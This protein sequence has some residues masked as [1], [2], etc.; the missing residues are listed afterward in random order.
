MKINVKVKP[1][2]RLVKIEGVDKTHFNIW[3]KEKPEKGR[4]NAGVIKALQKYFNLPA[5]A[6]EI[7]SGFKSKNKIIEIKR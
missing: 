6:I 7:V 1:A 5:A 3:I 2:S 4:A